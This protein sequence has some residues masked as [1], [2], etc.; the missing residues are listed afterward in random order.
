MH[1]R[2]TGNR[3]IKISDDLYRAAKWTADAERRSISGQIEFWAVL[4]RAALDNPDLSIDF[5]MQTL[6]AKAQSRAIAE[7]FFPE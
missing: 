3:S 2:V 7:P 6:I 1:S 4:G 5:I